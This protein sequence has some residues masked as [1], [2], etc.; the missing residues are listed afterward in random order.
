MNFVQIAGIA[1]CIINL[2]EA[3]ALIKI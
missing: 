1:I 3:P 2:G